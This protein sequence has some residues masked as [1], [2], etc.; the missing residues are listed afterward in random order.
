MTSTG[1]QLLPLPLPLPGN[2]PGE[3]PGDPPGEP[4]GEPLGKPPGNPPEEAPADPLLLLGGSVEAEQ[5]HERHPIASILVHP[6]GHDVSYT[7]HPFLLPA[8]P[9]LGPEEPVP[10]VLF[11]DKPEHEHFKHPIESTDVQSGEQEASYGGHEFPFPVVV[12]PL[13]ELVPEPGNTGC[14]GA[15][16]VTDPPPGTSGA[17]V[18]TCACPV[19]VEAGVVTEHVQ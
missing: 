12:F 3:P 1:G 19:P 10:V 5:V 13:P 6:D 2:P 18:V 11:P 16:V 7:G 9:T 14:P 15:N 4:P 8:P 17:A